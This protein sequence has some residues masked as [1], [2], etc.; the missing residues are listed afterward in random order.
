MSDNFTREHKLVEEIV[1]QGW[2][3]SPA[4]RQGY[5]VIVLER[6]GDGG[7]RFYHNLKPGETLRFSERVFGK[8]IALAVD[9]RYARSFPIEGQFAARERGRFVTL[10][11]NVRY[12]VTDARV[13]AME[14]LDPLGALR[15]KVIAV[16]NRRAH[17]VSRR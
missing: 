16:L 3:T 8:F 4:G 5:E 13:V 15:D 9:V 12:R 14:T 11:A 17:P 7:T 2:F 10:K 1:S 6:V